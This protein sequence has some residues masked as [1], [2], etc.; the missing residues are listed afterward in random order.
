MGFIVIEVNWE[1]GESTATSF[2]T[3]V[4]FLNH[5]NKEWKWMQEI[6][7]KYTD[8][9]LNIEL[10]TDIREMSK[11]LCFVGAEMIDRIEQFTIK[12]IILDGELIGARGAASHSELGEKLIND[13][14]G[15]D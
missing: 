7:E 12:Y 15:S 14:F 11:F 9:P 4:P 10:P 1:R 6:L 2:D 5:V 3:V 13:L 8:K